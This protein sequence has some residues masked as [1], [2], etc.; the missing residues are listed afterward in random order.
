MGLDAVFPRERSRAPVGAMTGVV[1]LFELEDY[2]GELLVLQIRKA[3]SG[4]IERF[5]EGIN[6]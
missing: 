6:T 1:R 3:T 4:V 5:A 2:L